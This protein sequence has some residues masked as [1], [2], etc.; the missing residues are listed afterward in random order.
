MRRLWAITLFVAL[1]LPALLPFLAAT[2]P[3]SNLPPCCRRGGRH[4]C[5]MMAMAEQSSQ[6]TSLRQEPAACPYRSQSLP[7]ARTFSFY[8]RAALYYYAAAIQHPAIHAQTA[9]KRLVSVARSHQKR[10]PPSSSHC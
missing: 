2:S 10:G 9:V 3:E 8:P 4:H 7:A 1:G 6:T 5:A